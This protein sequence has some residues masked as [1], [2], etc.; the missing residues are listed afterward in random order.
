MSHATDSSPK[1]VDHYHHGNLRHAI[2]KT[3][4][5]MI[6]SSGMA[7]LT[8]RAVSAKLGVSHAAPVYHFPTRAHL[9]AGLAEEGFRVFADALSAAAE[10]EASGRLLRVGKAYL[11]FAS[12]HPQH[13]QVMFGSELSTLGVRP[14]GLVAESTRALEVLIASSGDRASPGPL[15]KKALLAWGLVHGLVLLRQGPFLCITPEDAIRVEATMVE[16]L[17]LFVP[18]LQSTVL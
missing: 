9:L 17:E 13:Y 8:L 15:G 3:A 11:D 16:A 10:G 2:L 7:A 12:R 6:E 5:E 1:P 14:P 18:L 4:L